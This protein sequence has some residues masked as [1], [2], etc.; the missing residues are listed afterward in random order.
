V[1]LDGNAIASSGNYRNFYDSGG[2][3]YS[4]IID[5]RTGAPIRHA[6]AS[7]TVIAPTAMAADA[8]ST[9]LMVLGPDA[10]PALAEKE[11]IAALFIARD[12]AGFAETATPEFEPYRLG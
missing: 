3:R 12:K 4:H 2:T 6:L 7:V 9:A 5:P 8:L 10:G 11:N 1:E